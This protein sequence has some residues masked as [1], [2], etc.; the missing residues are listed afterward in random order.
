MHTRPPD[1]PGPAQALGGTA[2]GDA[3][4]TGPDERVTTGAPCWAGLMTPDPG[5]AMAFYSRVLG[6]TSRV[7][8]GHPG[9][10]LTALHHGVPVAGLTEPVLP[11]ATP[12]WTVYF[13]TH[14]LDRAVDDIRAVGGTVAVGPLAFE[15]GRAAWACDTA[16]VQFGA[17]E[18]PLSSWRTDGAAGAPQRM[19]LHTHDPFAA[20]LFYGH[21]FGW[22][23]PHATPFTVSYDDDRVVVRVSGQ[24][25]LELG[26]ALPWRMLGVPEAGW[27][28]HLRVDDCPRAVADAEAAGGQVLD[29][30]RPGP[31]GISAVVSH[32]AAGVVRL[33]TG[34]DD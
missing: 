30:P 19:E 25:V 26:D 23:A 9:R 6:W 3:A 21:V 20:A 18:A 29:G 34:R 33:V 27:T 31:H 4:P 17:W 28:P 12:A 2:T 16:G 5:R 14:R 32:A 13:A 24:A 22:D 11:S 15:G 1:P 7:A 8:R 10:G